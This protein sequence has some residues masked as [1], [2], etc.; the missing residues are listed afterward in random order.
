MW[1]ILESGFVE[2]SH[3]DDISINI[4]SLQRKMIDGLKD[5]D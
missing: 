5:Y 2:M 4:S 3:C 1:K